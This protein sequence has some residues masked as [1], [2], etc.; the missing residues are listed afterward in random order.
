MMTTEKSKI[1]LYPDVITCF[2]FNRIPKFASH[3]RFGYNRILE[4][5]IGP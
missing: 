1:R 4:F 2:G 3:H 5:F